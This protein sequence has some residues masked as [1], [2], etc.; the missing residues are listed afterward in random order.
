MWISVDKGTAFAGESDIWI[1]NMTEKNEEK[2]DMKTRIGNQWWLQR[3]KFKS[4]KLKKLMYPCCIILLNWVRIEFLN[5][6]LI[7]QVNNLLRLSHIYIFSVFQFISVFYSNNKSSIWLC[8]FYC[9]P[10]VTWK[11]KLL[12]HYTN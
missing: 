6:L 8:N 5:I 2:H 7:S 10:D 1:N 3:N 11:L 9:I 12:S 4:P